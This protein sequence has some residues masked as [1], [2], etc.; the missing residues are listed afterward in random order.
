MNE[1]IQVK[2]LPV[3]VE[4]LSEIKE[5]IIS[6]T[7]AALALPVTE[8]NYKEIKN[9][10]TGLRTDYDELETLRKQI[11]TAVMAPYDD[12][13]VTY[14]ECVSD[15]FLPADKQLAERIASVETSLK[16]SKANEVQ[17]YFEEYAASKGIDFLTFESLNLKITMAASKK[18]LI[19]QVIIFLDGVAED[20]EMIATLEHSAEILVEYKKSLN[21]SQAIKTVNDR[22]VAIEAELKHAEEAQQVAEEKAET[23]AAVDEVLDESFVAPTVEAIPVAEDDSVP[24]NSE[25]KVYDLAFEVHTPRLEH[26][27]AM[28]DLMESFREEGLTYGQIK[29]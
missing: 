14:K 20:L 16:A 26:I 17:E 22:H 11:K 10:R 7:Q 18:S 2:Q 8:E 4:Q 21:V 15:V 9:I 28:K 24:I 29:S 3:I 27:K 19:K 1:L 23:V 12:L 25:V 6:S 5:R 13:M